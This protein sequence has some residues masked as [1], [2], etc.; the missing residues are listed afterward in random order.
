[1]SLSNRDPRWHCER[2]YSM[3]L[4]E[5]RLQLFFIDTR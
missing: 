1:M 5:G 2:S 3:L 4:A